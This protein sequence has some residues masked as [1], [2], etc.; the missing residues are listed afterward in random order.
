MAKLEYVT[1]GYKELEKILNKPIGDYV[2]SGY[3]VVRSQVQKHILDLD[4]TIAQFNTSTDQNTKQNLLNNF[5]SINN[6]LEQLGLTK[7][8]P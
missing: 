4:R 2:G 1:K 6:S 5:I 8:A 3:D 7:V